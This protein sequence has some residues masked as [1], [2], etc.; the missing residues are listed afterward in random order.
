VLDFAEPAGANRRIA[1][2]FEGEGSSVSLG[3]VIERTL[4]LLEGRGALD[5]VAVLTEPFPGEYLVGARAQHLEQILMNLVMNAVWAAK[6][7]KRPPEVFIQVA[8][9]R[10]GEGGEVREVILEVADSGPGISPEN[11]ERIFDPFFTTRR[12]GEGTGLGLAITRRIV[13]ELGGRI[14]AFPRE[15]GGSLFRVWLPV[16]YE[17]MNAI[18]RGGT[19]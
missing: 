8:P 15:G 14:E 5:G 1:G 12:P 10:N 17:Q 7:G 6:E 4:S 9:S 13:R 18:H 3:G 2:G 19:G 16:I 11:L